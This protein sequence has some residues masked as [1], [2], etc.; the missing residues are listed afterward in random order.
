MRAASV[1]LIPV[2]LIMTL[3]ATVPATA[4]VRVSSLANAVTPETPQRLIEVTISGEVKVPGKYVVKTGEKLSSAL[5]KAGGYTDTAYLR[6]ACLIRERIRR[7]QQKSLDD[8]ARRLEDELFWEVSAPPSASSPGK[9]SRI[10]TVELEQKR[11]L[12][13][14]IKKLKAK[15]RVP[16]H[17]T[18]LRLL[19][20][21][22]NDIELENGDILVIP[23]TNNTVKVAGS[24]KSPR[25]FT[26]CEKCGYKSYIKASDGYSEYADTENSFVM[27]I[28]GSAMKL[29]GDAIIWNASKSRWELTCFTQDQ[30]KIEAGDV[31]LIPER[32]AWLKEI[33]DFPR[34]LMTI[35]EL[36]GVTVYLF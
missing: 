28:D 14:T 2:I 9:D 33:K 4:A 13:E 19:K 31:I 25:R 34:I 26:Y 8:M 10:N 22:E 16:I 27:K 17:L 7:D 32:I 15:G 35:A 1:I 36:T 5:A 20:G 30:I 12:I 18:H 23:E 24:V 11:K 6:G 3:L 29:T 21:S